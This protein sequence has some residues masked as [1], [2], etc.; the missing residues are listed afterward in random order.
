MHNPRIILYMPSAIHSLDLL[1]APALS[2]MYI[3]VLRKALTIEW[4]EHTNN[5]ACAN[6]PMHMIGSMHLIY[7]LK[8][9]E[10]E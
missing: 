6:D 9:P 2:K 5:P 7:S 10:E 8:G 4:L 3:Q 1:L